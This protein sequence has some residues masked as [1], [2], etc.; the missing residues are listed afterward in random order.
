MITSDKSNMRGAMSNTATGERDEVPAAPTSYERAAIATEAVEL[1]I[2]RV[3]ENLRSFTASAINA[4]GFYADPLPLIRRLD[5]AADAIK[6]AIRI[7]QNNCWPDEDEAD[8]APQPVSRHIEKLRELCTA[9]TRLALINLPEIEATTQDTDNSRR[10]AATMRRLIE[11]NK[12]I[13][14]IDCIL[15]N[16]VFPPPRVKPQ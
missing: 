3:R 7:I 10:L 16:G 6:E 12:H 13:E 8:L 5:S 11:I 14:D 1:R 15:H 9:Q 4:H 2:E